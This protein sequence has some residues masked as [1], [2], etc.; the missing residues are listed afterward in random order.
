MLILNIF[1]IK[2]CFSRPSLVCFFSRKFHIFLDTSIAFF[3]VWEWK[4]KSV[5]NKSVGDIFW[6]WRSGYIYH[7]LR[8]KAKLPLFYLRDAWCISTFFWRVERWIDVK[9]SLPRRQLEHRPTANRSQFESMPIMMKEDN[10][11]LCFARGLADILDVLKSF[12]KRVLVKNQSTTCKEKQIP[13]PP[14]D[15]RT[16]YQ[17]NPVISFSVA[18]WLSS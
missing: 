3:I 17:E 5:A 10:L 4:G 2:L 18:I 12:K 11:I 8:F 13:H 7:C 9:S 1:K 6:K 16:P 15:E 14:L